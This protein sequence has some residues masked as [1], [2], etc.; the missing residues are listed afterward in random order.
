M[1]LLLAVA[2]KINV[3]DR[4]TRG[5]TWQWQSGAP[6]HRLRGSVLGLLSFRAI[7]RAIAARAGGFGMRI[8]A[9][10][11]YLPADEMTAS[12]ATGVSFDEFVTRIGLPRDPGSA[13][14]G[15]TP[16]VRRVPAATHGAERDPH[17]H[18]SRADRR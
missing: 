13:H 10:D 5:G 4:A 9:H 6:I 18:R 12:G 17:Q 7:A 16:P 1:A 2:R 14:G 15:D 11:P 3:Y 8:T